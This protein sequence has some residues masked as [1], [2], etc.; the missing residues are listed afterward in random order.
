MSMGDIR[1]THETVS[2]AHKLSLKTK[3]LVNLRTE[4]SYKAY[5]KFLLSNS[6]QAYK[7]FEISLYYVRNGQADIKHLY[8]LLGNQQS[9]FF[10]RIKVWKQFESVNGW[11]IQTCTEKKWNLDLAVCYLFQGWYDI[12]RGRLPRAGKALTQAEHILRPSGMIERICRL[13]WVWA[14]LAEA[15]GEYE[16]GLRHVNDALLVCADKGF[17]LRLA[18]HFIVRGRL[19]LLQFNRENRENR[20]LVEKAGDD[21]DEALKIAEDTEYIWAKVDALEL[22]CTYHETRAQLSGFKSSEEREKARSY[23]LEASTIKE[24]LFLTEKQMEELKIQARK[25]FEEQTAGWD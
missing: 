9:E 16:K 19:Y 20:D 7:D 3:N 21:G 5:C 13:D 6:T 23:T 10:I 17:R 15:K 24:G 14:L 18:D 25:E 22:L 1:K 2:Q 12:C 4:F 11:N 8:S